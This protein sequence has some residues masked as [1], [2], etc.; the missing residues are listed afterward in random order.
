LTELTQSDKVGP[1]SN[2]EVDSMSERRRIQRENWSH[3]SEILS[4]YAAGDRDVDSCV[5]E[6]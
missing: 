6:R 4:R 3:E 1:L 5:W 2:L